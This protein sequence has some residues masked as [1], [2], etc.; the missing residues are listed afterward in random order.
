[1]GIPVSSGGVILGLQIKW[2]TSV[3]FGSQKI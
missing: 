3:S 2:D 1:L